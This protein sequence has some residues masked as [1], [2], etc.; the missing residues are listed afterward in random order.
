MAAPAGAGLV[1]A[2][3]FLVDGRPGAA[4]GFFLRDAA[5]LVAHFDVLGLA[6]LLPETPGQAA[7]VQRWL[8]VAAGQIAFGP[9]AAR[10]VT[11]FGASF[12]ADTVIARAHDVLRIIESELTPREWIALPGS[13]TIADVALYSYIASAPEG[14]VD[15]SPYPAIR[16]WLERVEALPGFVPFQKSAIGLVEAA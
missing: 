8:S 13:P 11:L 5:V 7:E 4:F 12:D 2:A 9:A 3:A 16:Q 14:N 6:L 15:L 10:L 1:A